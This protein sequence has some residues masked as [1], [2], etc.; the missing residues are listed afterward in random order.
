MNP[1]LSRDFENFISTSSD[2]AT[3]VEGDTGA[4][5]WVLTEQAMQVRQQVLDGLN[6]A[7]GGQVEPWDS[8]AIK[9]AGRKRLND[10]QI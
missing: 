5:Y 9:L 2:G 4:T 8:E 3:K 1:K 10:R 7:D 6:E